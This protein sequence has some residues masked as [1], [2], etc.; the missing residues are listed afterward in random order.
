MGYHLRDVP[1]DPEGAV[2]QGQSEMYVR[3]LHCRLKH[4]NKKP[5]NHSPSTQPYHHVLLHVL[6]S[7]HG[8]RFSV[9][10]VLSG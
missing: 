1:I 4:S 3:V 10:S 5:S 9:N 6:Q 8:H 2:Q 7:D